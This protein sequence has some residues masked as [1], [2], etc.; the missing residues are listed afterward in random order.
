MQIA[1]YFKTFMTHFFC[2]ISK[3]GFFFA[4]SCFTENYRNSCLVT[5][6]KLLEKL[7]KGIKRPLY[8]QNFH[9]VPVA[10][11]NMFASVLDYVYNNEQQVNRLN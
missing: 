6:V 1:Q 2:C 8:N 3:C 10:C 4:C 5:A 11:I 7:C 9:E